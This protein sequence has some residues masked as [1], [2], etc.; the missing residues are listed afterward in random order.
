MAD[1]MSKVE[2]HEFQEYGPQNNASPAKLCIRR[3][4]TEVGMAAEYHLGVFGW[5]R[6]PCVENEGSTT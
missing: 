4:D 3:S 6:S 5:A 2:F 1:E